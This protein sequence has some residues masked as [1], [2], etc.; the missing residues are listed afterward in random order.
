VQVQVQVQVQVLQV[1]VKE[2]ARPSCRR[3][4]LRQSWE[5][6]VKCVQ[7]YLCIE[8]CI[9]VTAWLC[10]R[11]RVGLCACMRGFAHA[12]RAQELDFVSATLTYISIYA[13]L[14]CCM[15][16]SVCTLVSVYV[17][18]C[19]IAFYLRERKA[20]MHTQAC[21]HTHTHTHTCTHA[22]THICT[23]TQRNKQTQNS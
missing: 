14:L 6:F 22:R 18:A 4:H 10:V 20:C 2:A 7:L 13:R 11:V 1:L 23:S 9:Y 16:M 12:L 21:R 19:F 8:T 15:H 3:Q 17:C 5:L